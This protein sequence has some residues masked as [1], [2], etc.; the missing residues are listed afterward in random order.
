MSEASAVTRRILAVMIMLC[1]SIIAIYAT[2]HSQ[3]PFTTFVIPEAK[4]GWSVLWG[5]VSFPSAK[6]V[7]VSLTLGHLALMMMSIASMTAGFYFTPSG[8]K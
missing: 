2:I 4:S 8:R 5:L 1:A 6:E 3:S 7:T